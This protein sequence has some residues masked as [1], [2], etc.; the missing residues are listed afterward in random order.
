MAPAEPD[1]GS[2]ITAAMFVASCSSMSLSSSFASSTPPVSAIPL[3]KAIPGCNV[4]GRWSTSI[5]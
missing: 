3:V 5:S 1:I 2:T 4:W